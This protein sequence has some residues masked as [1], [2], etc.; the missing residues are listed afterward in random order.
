MENKKVVVNSVDFSKL[1]SQMYI[2]RGISE[3]LNCVQVAQ[4]K[5]VHEDRTYE[6]G[7]GYLICE[8]DY[9][10]DSLNQWVSSNRYEQ[11]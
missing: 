1:E 5:K 6:A 2:L 8:L 4:E 11:Q 9:V 10:V 7:F 3:A